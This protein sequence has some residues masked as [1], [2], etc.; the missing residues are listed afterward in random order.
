MELRTPQEIINNLTDKRQ[1]LLDKTLET[2]ARQ[3]EKSFNGLALEVYID[4][5]LS[6]L[7]AIE[8]PIRKTLANKG[9][10]LAIGR[11]TSTPDGYA[12]TLTISAINQ[13]SVANSRPDSFEQYE[14]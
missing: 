11:C 12:T 4:E 3:L 13:A 2:I 10:H 9:W 14:R 7:L 1:L 5:P 6:M 8:K